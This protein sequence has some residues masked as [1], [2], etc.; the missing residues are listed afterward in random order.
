MSKRPEVPAVNLR[1]R[2]LYLENVGLLREGRWILKDVSFSVP[3]G[4]MAAILGPNGSGKSTFARLL[5][6]YLWPTTGQIEVL[7]HRFGQTD[8]NALRRSIALVQPA[9]PYDVDGTLSAREVVLTGVEGTLALYRAIEAR[10][11]DQ[12][13][14]LLEQVG[15]RSVAEHPYRTLSSGE[16]LRCL[17]A[18]ALIKRP[19]LLILDE[20]T[21]G[22]DLLARE[23]VLATVDLLIRHQGEPSTTVLL[24]THH[25]EELTPT[26][27]QVLLL[28]HGQVAASGTPQEVLNEPILSRVYGCPVSVRQESGRWSLHVHPDGWEQLLSH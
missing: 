3:R 1:Q 6:G 23:Q 8:L 17:I 22:L 5:C 24:I 25:V 13:M 15:L 14:R 28:E 12:A 27:R 20:P 19:G 10:E 16:R 26:T 18:R 11:R 21:A 7:G 9:G 4:E 2:A